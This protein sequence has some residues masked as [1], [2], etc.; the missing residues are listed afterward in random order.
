MLATRNALNL[1]LFELFQIYFCKFHK[2]DEKC[3]KR[4]L[5]F[6][7]SFSILYIR[8]CKFYNLLRPVPSDQR[9]AF[10]ESQLNHITTN[11]GLDLERN[12]D[13]ICW[14]LLGFHCAAEGDELSLLRVNNTRHHP[15]CIKC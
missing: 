10:Q 11:A 14:R 3:K 4:G 15:I 13:L 8:R 2:R 5:L 9:R 7:F 12:Y 6:A 1:I